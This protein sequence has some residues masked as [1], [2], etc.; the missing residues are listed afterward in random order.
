MNPIALTSPSWLTEFKHEDFPSGHSEL[1]HGS[2]GDLGIL[3]EKQ[4]CGVL[5][6][7]VRLVSLHDSELI[8][9]VTSGK[10]ECGVSMHSNIFNAASSPWPYLFFFSLPCRS[11]HSVAFRL[12]S[13][14]HSCTF[15]SC[16]PSLKTMT[17]ATHKIS[18]RLVLVPMPYPLCCCPWMIVWV[19]GKRKEQRFCHDFLTHGCWNRAFDLQTCCSQES[20]KNGF[21]R[22]WTVG[23]CSWLKTSW[24]ET[25]SQTNEMP[26]ASLCF[27][28]SQGLP[29][30][31]CLAW[32]VNFWVFFSEFNISPNIS[33]QDEKHW[34]GFRC[35]VFPCE[36][37][38]RW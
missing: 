23:P 5:S 33:P 2:S 17:P 30:V 15:V 18:W 20:D 27:F 6:R 37:F 4:V 26:N 1:L 25:D 36:G 29:F 14:P 31:A 11:R 9:I 8:C 28:A 38:Y 34:N 24:L 32:W 22:L 19:K 3:A 7:V 10:K 12:F 35:L 13:W 16:H 21:Q